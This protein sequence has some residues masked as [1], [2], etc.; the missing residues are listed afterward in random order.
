MLLTGDV[1][2]T[3]SSIF[4]TGRL[5]GGSNVYIGGRLLTLYASNLG[6]QSSKIANFIY[7]NNDDDLGLLYTNPSFRALLVD[8]A[9]FIDGAFH[10]LVSTYDAIS[11][12]AQVYFDQSSA[13]PANVG[14]IR[15][16]GTEPARIGIAGAGTGVYA[17]VIDDTRIYS[18]ALKAA[19]I[20]EL[21]RMN[22]SSV[23]NAAHHLIKSP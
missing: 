4:K 14:Q 11:N 6:G 23:V 3:L 19:E 15:S 21:Q 1:S 17:G 18:R 7:G 5:Y 22:S 8:D 9:G 16:A 12:N 20:A 13:G 10:N 2:F